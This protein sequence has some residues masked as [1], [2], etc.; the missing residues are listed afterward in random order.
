MLMWFLE[1]VSQVT[2]NNKRHA[3][4]VSTLK[5]FLRKMRILAKLIFGLK[6]VHCFSFGK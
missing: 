6:T 1:K 3:V 4:D 2:V 5:N